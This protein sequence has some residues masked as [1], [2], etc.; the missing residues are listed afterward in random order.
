VGTGE[1]VCAR[2]TAR[3]HGVLSRRQ[4]L[5][6]GFSPSTIDRRLRSGSWIRVLPGVYRLAT[7]PASWI[8]QL[9]AAWLWAREPSAVWGKAAARLWDMD[10]FD[11]EWIGISC[12]R[13][14]RPQPGIH[15]RCVAM[16]CYDV[17][18]RRD[19]P[20]TTPLRTVIDLG[21]VVGERRVER[22]LED[23]LR[24]GLIA[25]PRLEGRLAS[26]LRGHRGVTTL[27]NVLAAR[28]GPSDSDFE[29][30]LYRLF[31]NSNLPPFVPQFEIG[32]GDGSRMRVDCAWPFAKVAVEGQ[33]FRWHGDISD[34][35][36]D[37]ARIERLK[38]LGWE[39]IQV[40]WEDVRRRP[41]HTVER[42]RE[43]LAPRLSGRF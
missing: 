21:S 27:R 11:D 13:H 22:A 34:R 33:S 1:H 36:R 9:W 32:N 23:C 20:C 42:I 29:I 24:R 41:H 4:A 30:A 40:T 43:R 7:A 35:Q 26:D 14:L 3:Q 16:P 15:V 2:L 6:I 18:R 31:K 25:M 17:C 39:V 10:G 37:I 8:Q 28:V 38:D 5:E 19:L 12:P